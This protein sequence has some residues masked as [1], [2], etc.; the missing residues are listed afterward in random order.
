MAIGVTNST[1]GLLIPCY[2]TQICNVQMW[3]L[4]KQGK[5]L[6]VALLINNLQQKYFLTQPQHRA[7]RR[8]FKSSW[9]RIPVLGFQCKYLYVCLHM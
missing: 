3:I 8:I 2:L 5:R 7:Y 9:N 6:V 4:I 1:L